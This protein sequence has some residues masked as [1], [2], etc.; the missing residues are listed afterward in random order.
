MTLKDIAELAQTSVST[1]SRSLNDSDLVSGE[2]KRRIKQ[3]AD[4]HGFEFNASARGLVTSTTGTIGVIL[5]ENYDR[6]DVLLYHA[7]LHN[8]FRKSLE[9]A[10]KDMIVAFLKNRFS[11][12]RNVEKLVTRKK[13]DG[14]II[15][16]SEIDTETARF[17]EQRNVPFVMTQYPPAEPTPAYDVIYSDNWTGGKLVAE[18]FLGRGFTSVACIS[19]GTETQSRQRVAGFVDT[20]AANEIIIDPGLIL[21]GDFQSNTAVQLVRDNIDRL[22]HV[23][24]LF[25][26]ND[27]MAFGAMQALQ[28]AGLRVPEDIAV[29]GYDDSPLAAITLPGLTSVH[30]S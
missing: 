24:A 17:L 28:A 13:V 9:R 15:V 2:T 26:V 18:H 23:S 1:V 21:T 14:L 11:G 10:D 22:R 20:C 7:A 8:D 3:I 29:V 25:A 6:F 19:G 16:Q 12:L 27:L 30:Q 5:P 4:E